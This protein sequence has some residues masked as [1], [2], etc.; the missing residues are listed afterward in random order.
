MM[1]TTANVIDS[2][3]FFVRDEHGRDWVKN[4]QIWILSDRPERRKAQAF[5]IGHLLNK[6][7][8]H[9]V[10]TAIETTWRPSPKA[11]TPEL[12]FHEDTQLLIV[13]A[14][15]PLIEVVTNV[16]A[17]LSQAVAMKAPPSTET[18]PTQP[19]KG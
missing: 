15:P 13:F 16:L 4:G 9:D 19:T 17:Q 12:K 11:L 8:V 6:F 18:K 10:T 5:F 3:R 2:L 1:I 14:E 7:K